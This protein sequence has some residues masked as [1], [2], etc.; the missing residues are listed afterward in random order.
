MDAQ[1]FSFRQN[2]IHYR[3]AARARNNNEG[4]RNIFCAIKG[5]DGFR[6]PLV[7]AISDS[8][9]KSPICYGSAGNRGLESAAS[10][11]LKIDVQEIAIMKKLIAVIASALLATTVFEQTAAAADAN[12]AQKAQLKANSEKMEAQDTANKKKAEAQSDAE[13][14]QASANEDKASAQADADK[15][16]A[17]GAK[18]TTPA[19]ASGARHDAANA[20]AKANKK[21]QQAQSKA[22]RK[23]HDAAND[24]NVAQAKADEKK[25]EAQNDANKK[26]AEAKV[27][28]AKKQ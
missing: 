16:A 5:G 26:A 1:R 11:P 9:W 2:E 14:A 18:A 24:A 7:V 13:K 6:F 15:K 3:R 10:L 17:K 23:K 8:S 27:D 12:D 4:E 25:V 21:M 20:Q 22:D 19:E 28:A